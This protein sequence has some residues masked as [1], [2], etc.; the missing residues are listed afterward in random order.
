MRISTKLFSAPVVV[1]GIVRHVSRR[2]TL[3]ENFRVVHPR[4]EGEGY[5][6]VVCPPESERPWLVPFD[7]LSLDDALGE[8]LAWAG[9]ELPLEGW[10]LKTL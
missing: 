10:S 9:K 5:K 2:V 7:F 3:G 6:V 8:A 1:G 4:L